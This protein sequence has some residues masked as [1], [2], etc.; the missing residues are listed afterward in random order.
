M[1]SP[2][3]N[4]PYLAPRKYLVLKT[5]SPRIENEN[6]CQIEECFEVIELPHEEYTKP[7]DIK[8]VNDELNEKAKKGLLIGLRQEKEML[9]LAEPRINGIWTLHLNEKGYITKITLF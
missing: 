2:F 1:S 3:S 4:T 8:R 6:A 7:A 5:T 9:M